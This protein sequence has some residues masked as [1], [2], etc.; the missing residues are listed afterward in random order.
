MSRA[1]YLK[2][3]DFLKRLDLVR[4]KKTYVKII[5]LDIDELPV[6]TI[7][8][9]ITSGSI[10][11]DGSSSMRRTCNL[12]FLATDKENDLTNVDNLLSINKKIKIEIGISNTIDKRYDDIIWFKQGVFVIVQPSINHTLQGTTI[13]LSCKDKMCLLNGECGGTLPTSV[14]FDYYE[15]IDENGNSENKKNLVYDIIE[16]LLLFY[17]NEKP[18]NI[19]IND[20][21]KERKQI[22]R[23]VGSQNLYYNLN[24]HQFTLDYQYVVDN[25]KEN[26][27]YT[28]IYNSYQEYIDA[29]Q[30]EDLSEDEKIRASLKNSNWTIFKYNDN[31]GY[32]YTENT[33]AGSLISGFG[34]SVA[35]ILDKIKNSL[36]NFEYFYDIEGRFVFQEIKNYLNTSYDMIA[37]YSIEDRLTAYDENNINILNND[38]Y[39]ID[40]DRT[41]RVIYNFTEDSGLISSYSNSLTYINLKND[42]HIWGKNNN[43]LPIHYHLA[44]QKKPPISSKPRSVVFLNGADNKPDGRIKLIISEEDRKKAEELKLKI[45]DKYIPADWRAEMYLQGLEILSLKQRPEPHQQELLDLFDSI[46]DFSIE[47]KNENDEI[48]SYGAFKTDILKTPN[49]LS[50]FFDYLEPIGKIADCSINTIGQKVHIYNFDKINYLYETEVP[51]IIIVDIDSEEQANLVKEKCESIGQTYTNV[52]EVI[53]SRIAFNTSGHSAELAARDLLYQYTNYTS[54][55]NLQVIPIYYLEPNRRITVN[56]K[57][58]NIY[59][60]YII[61]SIALPLDG[62]TTMTISANKALQRI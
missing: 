10:N 20:L 9:Q 2:D 25:I 45:T 5:V 18:T 59:G 27:P 35:S 6:R 28:A 58:S 22:V 16:T 1:S 4:N 40:L 33:Y 43:D 11:I 30:K 53:Y 44:I 48:I 42:F 50:Y 57:V 38:N 31:I 26:D 15:Q 61:K 14:T 23:W 47:N 49:N 17:G 46:Y 60:D 3:K 41:G 21:P 55:I 32:T 52:D 24:T 7:E 19:F 62:K 8:G 54:A 56:D 51:N 29:L 36:G 13:S 12:S 34:D 37:A 39:Y